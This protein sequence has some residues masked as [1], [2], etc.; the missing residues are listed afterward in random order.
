MA[1]ASPSLAGLAEA[2]LTITAV[3]AETSKLV[4]FDASSGVDLIDAVNASCAVLGVW[5]V[6]EI[7]E[8]SFMDGGVWSPGNAQLAAGSERVL[9]LSPFGPFHLFCQWL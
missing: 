6:V 4:A 9:I 7:C 8:R 2:A 1:G 5:P 3:D